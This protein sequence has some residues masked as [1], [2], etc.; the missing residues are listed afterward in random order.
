MQ[1]LMWSAALLALYVRTRAPIRA[2]SKWSYHLAYE[3]GNSMSD[4]HCWIL[5]LPR[6]SRVRVY[7][8]VHAAP[9]GPL[10]LLSPRI[11][12]SDISIACGVL[13]DTGHAI[14]QP[15]GAGANPPAA[16]AV[17]P[18]LVVFSHLP[19]PGVRRLVTFSIGE[20]TVHNTTQDS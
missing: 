5:M 9:R 2:V 19:R 11:S 3:T 14:I 7:A 12:G 1:M 17:I 6:D 16:S 8:C 10:D 20:I 18:D 4:M 15:R 13:V